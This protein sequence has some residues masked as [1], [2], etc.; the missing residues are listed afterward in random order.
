M[1][2][3]GKVSNDAPSSPTHT[4]TSNARV[5]EIVAATSV[6][7][8]DL[9]QYIKSGEVA[10]AQPSVVVKRIMNRTY[11]ESNKSITAGRIVLKETT[12]RGEVQTVKYDAM[13]KKLK[14]SKSDASSD[15]TKKTPHYQI[16]VQR[17]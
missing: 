16:V 9:T 4:V 7:G 10:G 2:T 13:V 1:A 8:S 15:S 17:V 6:D 12:A 14:R 11:K 5:F 3:Q